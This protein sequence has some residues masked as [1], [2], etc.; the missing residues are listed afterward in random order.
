MEITRK[1]GKIS[2]SFP[3]KLKRYNPYDEKKDYGEYPT[4]TGLIVHNKRNGNN[5]DEI[6]FAT[7]ID[8]DYKDKPDQVGSIVIAWYDGAKEFKKECKKLEIGWQEITL[9]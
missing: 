6:G 3:E 2:F 9:E 4:F 8:M 1:N 5:Y 7:T